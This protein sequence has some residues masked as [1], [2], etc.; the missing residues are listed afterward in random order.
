[1]S[2]LD[3]CNGRTAE[4]LRREREHIEACRLEADMKGRW[5]E[6]ERI[7]GILRQG[8]AGPSAAAQDLASIESWYQRVRGFAGT[9]EEEKPYTPNEWFIQRFPE[10]AYRY[11]AA[12][13]SEALSKDPFQ[14]TKFKRALINEDFFAAMLGG[15]K[16][17]GHKI[18]YEEQS[19]FWFLDPKVDLFRLASP[20][21]MELLLS[22][23]LVKCLE[24]MGSRVDQTQFA[25]DYLEPHLIKRIV[26]KSKV[27]LEVDSS[28]FNGEHAHSR[29]LNG[30]V[31]SPLLIN[32]PEEFIMSAFQPEEGC[33]VL[34]TDAYQEFLCYCQLGNFQRIKFKEFKEIAKELILE[35]Y[36]LGFRHDIRT[37]EGRQ[38]HG[39]KHIRLIPESATKAIEAA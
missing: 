23:Y 4:Q 12:F 38:T 20:L 1:M 37:A 9:A 36:Q 3:L 2:F 17:L 11:G 16:G 32:P 8:S 18:V 25:R 31:L 7:L 5:R 30:R 29:I 19:G 21:K 26:E 6:S 15:E 34:V 10:E 39:W 28:F 27:V 35:R 24:A 13:F 14:Q 33:S 22:N